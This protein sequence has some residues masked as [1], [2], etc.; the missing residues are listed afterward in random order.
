MSFELFPGFTEDVDR[1]GLEAICGYLLKNY[2]AKFG[3][4][5]I[6][7]PRFFS[8][9]MQRIEAVSVLPFTKPET[10]ATPPSGLTREALLIE[11]SVRQVIRRLI[12]LW[13]DFKILDI[14]W[15]SKQ[16]EYAA[17]I[18]H[19][20]GSTQELSHLNERLLFEYFR[21]V[22]TLRDKSIREIS[23]SKALLEKGRRLS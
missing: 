16:S 22:H 1:N 14:F 23:A 2:L 10:E 20:E 6:V 19:L 17:R 7:Y 15:S 18:M 4:V 3:R 5:F 21:Q 11:P 12:E 13:L 9:T 8:L